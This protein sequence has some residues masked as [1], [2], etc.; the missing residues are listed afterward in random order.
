MTDPDKNDPRKSDPDETDPHRSDP[1]KKTIGDTLRETFLMQP[2]A[3]PAQDEAKHEEKEQMTE[4]A[5]EFR[6]LESNKAKTT[7]P[8]PDVG[9][10]T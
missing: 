1:G 6:D 7:T 3:Y 10:R 8:E 4:P 5:E 9:P 2:P